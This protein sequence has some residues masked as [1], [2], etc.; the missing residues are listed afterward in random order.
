LVNRGVESLAQVPCAPLLGF[1]TNRE[2][3]SI[4][5]T[6]PDYLQL[7][8]SVGRA[9]YPDKKGSISEHSPAILQRLGINVAVFVEHSNQFFDSRYKCQALLDDKALLTAMA[10]VDLNPVRSVMA[11]TPEKSEFTSICERI[12][13]LRQSQGAVAPVVSVAPLM[14][15]MPM[16]KE[17]GRFRLHYMII[18]NWLIGADG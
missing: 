5:F 12:K 3:P 6:L 8:D 15:M 13:E 11:E 2:L 14:P 1:A 7:L 10:Y 16:S 17:G 18:L 9:V 4:P